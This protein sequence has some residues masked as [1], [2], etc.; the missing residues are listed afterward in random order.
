MLRV[1]KAAAEVGWIHRPQYRDPAEVQRIE[2]LQRN[3]Y[4]D[5]ARID[6][7]GPCGFVVRLDSRLVLGERKLE[8]RVRVDMTVGHVVHDLFHRPPTWPVSRLELVTR[9]SGNRRSKRPRCFSYRGDEDRVVRLADRCVE[10]EFSDGVSKVDFV[11]GG[12][13][14]NN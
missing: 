14:G 5:A 11:S 6:Q 7:L 2:Q 4:R 13:H 10:V 9:H 12:G 3:L 8:A 1:A